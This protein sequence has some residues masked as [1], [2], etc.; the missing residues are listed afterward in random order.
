MYSWT[1]KSSNSCWS[2]NNRCRGFIS[3]CAVID[4]LGL[5]NARY[6]FDNTSSF[7]HIFHSILWNILKGECYYEKRS[8]GNFN[9]IHGFGLYIAGPDHVVFD[10]NHRMDCIC[11][12]QRDFG[13]RLDR[14]WHLRT[15]QIPKAIINAKEVFKIRPLL[16][17]IFS[18]LYYG[19]NERR[20]TYV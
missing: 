16:F 2:G 17:R 8:F 1:W 5:K 6:C 14:R 13:H 11:I 18:I 19:E 20:Y 15:G 10:Q 7:S 3:S 9:C 4:D 12:H